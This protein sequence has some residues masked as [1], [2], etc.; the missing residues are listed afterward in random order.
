[1]NALTWRAMQEVV[2]IAESAVARLQIL[3]KPQNQSIA[4]PD[5]I[6]LALVNMSN[7]LSRL[8]LHINKALEEAKRGEYSA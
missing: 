2:R 5:P 7:E 4:E 3:Y 1:M 6:R 8:N